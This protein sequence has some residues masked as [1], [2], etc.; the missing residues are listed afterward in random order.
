MYDSQN[1]FSKTTKINEL[2]AKVVILGDHAV[3]K[4]SIINRFS[5]SDNL[6]TSPT[7]GIFKFYPP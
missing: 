6:T 5:G 1:S 7:V 2:Q 3:G 4:T